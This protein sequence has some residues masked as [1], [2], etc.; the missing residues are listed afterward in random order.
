MNKLTDSNDYFL[1]QWIEGRMTDT[2]LKQKVSATD[3]EAFLQLR[4]SLGGLKFADPDMETNYRSIKDKKIANLDRKP[5]RIRMY[6][7]VSV[8]AVLL[9]LV[10]LYQVF[11][12]S[13]QAATDYGQTRQLDLADGSQVILNNRSSVAYPNG[14]ALWRKI[15]LNGEAFFRVSKGKTFTVETPSGSV[16]VLGTQ[17]NV[18]SRNGFFEVGCYEG[19]VCVISQKRQVVLQKGQS[20]RFYE[21]A[22]ERWAQTETD[23]GWTHG[24]SSFKNAPIESVLLQLENQYNRKV[25]YPQS[26]KN[27]RFTGSFTHADIE[28]ALRSICTPLQVRFTNTDGTIVLAE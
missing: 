28:T 8:A 18:I 7:L 22:V 17:F 16:T 27:I 10:G 11:V 14:F 20:V 26:L 23:P 1:S 6:A 9:L 21:N 15:E 19:K 12:F 5:K 4:Q 24:E 13:N 2:E 3:Y 25:V